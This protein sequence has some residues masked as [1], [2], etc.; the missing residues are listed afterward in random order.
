MQPHATLPDAQG[1]L[2]S[3][4]PGIRRRDDLRIGDVQVTDAAQGIA[5]EAALRIELR[6][7]RQVL[8]LTAAAI[9]V[10]VVWAWRL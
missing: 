5:H 2:A 10:P 8:Q 1:D 7:G 3:V 9:V 6:R 4:T